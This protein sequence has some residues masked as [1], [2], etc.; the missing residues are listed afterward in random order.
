MN[1]LYKRSV[2]KDAAK[3]SHLTLQV[4][5]SDLLRKKSSEVNLKEI[6]SKKIK[7]VISKLKKTLK[8]YKKLI[9]KGKGIAAV[10]VG[11]PFKIA[12]LYIDKKIETIINPKI[13]KKSKEVF[14]YPE[15]CMS[16]NPIIAKV[17]RPSWVEVKYFDEKG[18]EKIWKN[19]KDL[20]T[21]RVFQHE[22]DHMR[23]II[24]IDLVNSKDLILDSDPEF[25]KNAKFKKV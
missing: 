11:F 25:F 2:F 19:K 22:I 12:I 8:Q 24:N 3:V 15:I 13:T 17:V 14:L 10:Q 6:K 5:E 16:A 1:T 18:N 21:N 4:G 20:I 7:S 9:G 23:G